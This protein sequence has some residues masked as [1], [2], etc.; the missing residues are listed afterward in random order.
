MEWENNKENRGGGIG[1]EKGRRDISTRGAERGSTISCDMHAIS[2][3]NHIQ[4][5]TI[6]MCGDRCVK[7]RGAE[8]MCM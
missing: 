3:H 4:H 6:V 5:N 7:I 2:I 1:V 8:G